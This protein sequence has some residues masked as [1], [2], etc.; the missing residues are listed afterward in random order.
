MKETGLSGVINE[1]YVCMLTYVHGLHSPLH[2]PLFFM[3]AVY[4]LYFIEFHEIAFHYILMKK[5]ALQYRTGPR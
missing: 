1:R 3:F 2:K 4:L 5:Y